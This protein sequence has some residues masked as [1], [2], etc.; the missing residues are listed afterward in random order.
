M[1]E[2][3]ST[4]LRGDLSAL[5]HIDEPYP[6]GLV[7]RSGGGPDERRRSRAS[8]LNQPA[9]PSTQQRQSHSRSQCRHAP[10]CLTAR[11][12]TVR[13]SGPWQET[14]SIHWPLDRT[15]HSVVHMPPN[16]T[17][18]APL[19][20]ACATIQRQVNTRQSPSVQP[21]GFP[22]A[23]NRRTCKQTWTRYL[24]GNLPLLC[25]YCM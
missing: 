6:A 25:T 18:C 24:G 15:L 23:P 7:H 3:V 16:C 4:G 2:E 13:R 9:Q 22:A 1:R 12:G 14:G 21:P 5:K 19:C 17:E 11:A 10:L 8:G 20:R